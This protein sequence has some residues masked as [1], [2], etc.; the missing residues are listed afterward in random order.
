[1]TNGF[2]RRLR[3]V[4]SNKN[5]DDCSSNSP[6]PFDR[7]VSD[8]EFP[9]AQNLNLESSAVWDLTAP[10]GHGLATAFPSAS[11]QFCG[12]RLVRAAEEVEDFLKGDLLTVGHVSPSVSMLPSSVKRLTRTGKA[13][14]SKLTY[15]TSRRKQKD[16]WAIQR[17][18]AMRSARQRLGKTQQEIANL[19]G[20]DDRETISQYESGTIK[21]IDPAY[22]PKLSLALGMPAQQLSRTAWSARDEAAD[23]K[24][25]TVARQLAYNFDK[26]PLAV[27]NQIRDAVANY[28]R[29]VKAHGKEAADTL[30]TPQIAAEPHKRRSKSA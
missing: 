9:L 18:A 3:L 14:L 10:H 5:S 25:S 23:L 29:L 27:Q 16:D 30:L 19:I 28:E 7:H 4:V 26:L 21:D 6:A 22:I 11:S 8:S 13:A 12:Q 17:G 1:M 20:M 2:Q 24:I 15:M